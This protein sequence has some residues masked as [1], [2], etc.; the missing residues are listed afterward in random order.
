[1]PFQQQPP[2]QQ[3]PQQQ[4]GGYDSMGSRYPS[5]PSYPPGM[6]GPIPG[7]NSQPMPSQQQARRLDPDQMPS[8]IQVM[9]DDKRSRSG[10]FA[11]NQ[12]GLVPPL[13][14]TPFV[15]QDQGNSGPR[16]VRS[17]MYRY[18]INNNKNFH[19]FS[20]FYI[21]ICLFSVPALP[22]MMKQTAV[23]FGLVISPFAQLE[24][25]EQP[26]PVVDMGELGPVRCGRCK[27]Y[28][29]PFMQFIDGGRRFQC[30]FCKATSEVPAEYFQH[31]DHTG[32]RMDK[33][34]RPELCLGSYEFVG[35]K[36]YCRN[37]VFPKPPAYI[38]VLDV[39]YNNVKSGLVHLLCQNIKSIL[40]GLPRESINGQKSR[41]GFITYSKEV[42][43]YNIKSSLAQPQMMVVGD[44]E[45]INSVHNF[46]FK[47][48]LI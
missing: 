30:P 7:P 45:V 38:F 1:M 32:M 23:P 26:P 22:D 20:P 2:M 42:H 16:F 40:Q 14:T 43:F 3:Q 36:D 34:Q 8:A 15:T 39:S 21:E 44:V 11:T 46:I 9:E 17:S 48:S 33:Y 24:E 18:A 47:F 12:K 6:S 27:A 19:V 5:S 35:T 25:G 37:N 10:P 31:L 28:M 41:V 13:V 4:Q 29:C